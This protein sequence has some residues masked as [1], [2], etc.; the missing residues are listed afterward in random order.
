MLLHE[1]AVFH[2][3]D[4]LITWALYSQLF[5]N[6]DKHTPTLET[7]PVLSRCR[8]PVAYARR[9]YALLHCVYVDCCSVSVDSDKFNRRVSL[10]VEPL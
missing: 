4:V 6:G 8:L 10:V 9:M 2:L 1:G 7:D 3:P 5:K